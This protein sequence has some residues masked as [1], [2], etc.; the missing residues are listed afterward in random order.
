MDSTRNHSREICL[1]GRALPMASIT[2]RNLILYTT[3]ENWQVV[4]LKEARDFSSDKEFMY[5]F[6]F[7][8][9]DAKFFY[10]RK[11]EWESLSVDLL[12]HPGMFADVQGGANHRDDDGAKRVFFG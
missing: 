1:D 9:N 12:P 4:N 5:V 10:C 6:K 7:L 2:M 8:S 11:L 3:H